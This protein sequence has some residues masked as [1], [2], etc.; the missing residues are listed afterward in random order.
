MHIIHTSSAIA[1]LTICMGTGACRLV[2][3]LERRT[4]VHDLKTL[5]LLRTI[6][7][8]PNP[9]VPSLSE[10][11]QATH[12]AYSACYMQV[13]AWRMFAALFVKFLA[14]ITMLQQ[15]QDLDFHA[16]PTRHCAH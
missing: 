6:E 15:R 4:L 5:E 12:L 16:F 9:K 10:H 11:C 7:T 8:E 1:V 14:A 3:V 13:Q 2:V